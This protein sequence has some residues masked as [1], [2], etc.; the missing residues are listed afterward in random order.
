MSV[1]THACM[2]AQLD[3][4]RP[5]HSLLHD[6]CLIPG[7]PNGFPPW[8][9]QRFHV[10]AV[11]T[12]PCSWAFYEHLTNMC[13]CSDSTLCSLPALASCSQSS[14]IRRLYTWPFPPIHYI[15]LIQSTM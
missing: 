15:K 6:V 13:S 1:R 11:L 8:G 9:W 7:P 3:G 4:K 5:D 14:G 10:I 2:R 12:A